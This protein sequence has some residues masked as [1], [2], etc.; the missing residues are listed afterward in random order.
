MEIIWRKKLKLEKASEFISKLASNKSSLTGQCLIDDVYCKYSIHDRDNLI[1]T[2]SSFIHDDF[3]STKKQ[4]HFEEV[5]PWGFEYF[6]KN[7]LNVISFMPVQTSSWYRSP[8]F[9]KFVISLGEQLHN[10]TNV[11]GYGG[12]MGGYGVSAFANVL[13]FKTVLLMNPVSTLNKKLVPFEKRFLRE[14][15]Y[16]WNGLFHDGASCECD[17]YVIYDNIFSLDTKHANR[18]KKLTHLHLPGVGHKIPEHLKSIGMLNW[19]VS[20]FLK[21]KID[22][23]EFYKQARARKTYIGYYQWLLSSENKHL[24]E[25]RAAIIKYYQLKLTKI[26]FIEKEEVNLIKSL[27][28]E[29]PLQ[30]INDT[31]DQLINILITMGHV[32]AS[33]TLM[34]KKKEFLESLKNFESMADF[35]RD[36]GFLLEQEK[37]IKSA[38]TLMRYASM[39]RPNGPIINNKLLKYKALLNQSAEGEIFNV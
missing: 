28:K 12:S 36:V 21:G 17:G 37:E 26:E 34:Q 5:L 24:T 38:Y 4:V 7:N 22:K 20:S 10:F 29:I 23:D 39:L 32:E 16:D 31:L 3:I 33:S 14:T 19:I 2:F 1:V 35:L 15:K 18:Y 13:N 30:N 11:S 25:R 8:T 9:H 27:L 6:K